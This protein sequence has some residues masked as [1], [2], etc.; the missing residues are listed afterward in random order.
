MRHAQRKKTYIPAR[1]TQDR[2]A[3]EPEAI[4][5]HVTGPSVTS[6]PPSNV[7]TVPSDEGASALELRLIDLIRTFW[8]YRRTIA[9]YVGAG[10]TL[11]VLMALAMGPSYTAT[12]ILQPSLQSEAPAKG[13]Q[14]PAL[15]AGMLLESEI[16]LIALQP[17]PD[18]LTIAL[19][20]KLPMG[21]GGRSV[22]TLLSNA[23]SGLTGFLGSGGDDAAEAPNP[24]ASQ[25]DITLDV[26]YRKRTYLIEVTMRASTPERAA[27]FANA[28][29]RQYARN[30]ELRQ[31]KVREAAAQLALTELKASYGDRHPL[32][33][34][35]ESELTRLRSDLGAG[36]LAGS[37]LTDAA[38]A[39]PARAGDAHLNSS[40]KTIAM[41]AILGLISALGFVLF[42]E[43]R[44]LL[45]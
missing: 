27:A 6:G 45:T 36:S 44:N 38:I 14:A 29:A 25:S 32:V 9:V 37:D 5:K 20:E 1:G 40:H 11:G 4:G 10:M 35:A 18:A 12:A 23:I 31:L 16:Q 17:L 28:V 22:S 24:L 21:R 13:V 41:W 2:V 19:N 34:R 30:S 3:K 26:G 42:K 43:R 39:V 8:S 33:V 15:D 7:N